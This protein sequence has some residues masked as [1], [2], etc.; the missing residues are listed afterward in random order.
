M[1]KSFLSQQTWFPQLLP[2]TQAKLHKGLALTLTIGGNLTKLP[3]NCPHELVS[4]LIPIAV[5]FAFLFCSVRYEAGSAF[6]IPRSD[7][8][9]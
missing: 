8:F 2:Q 9:P 3:S 4:F 5:D 1:F 7:L 6:W